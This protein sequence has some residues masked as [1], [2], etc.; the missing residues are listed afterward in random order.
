MK[1]EVLVATMHQKDHSLIEI[2][3]I[4]TDAII[5]NQCDK[6]EYKEFEHNGRI[7]KF[8]SNKER[9]LS[10][11]RNLAIR[12]ATDDICVIADDDIVYENGYES[13]IIKAY[14]EIPEADIIVFDVSKLNSTQSSMLFGEHPFRMRMRKALRVNSIRITFKRQSI[15]NKGI[16][17]N[18]V[19]GAGSIH[20]HGEEN[21]FIKTCIKKGLK[22]F[23]YPY[24]I[25]TITHRESTWFKGYDEKYFYDIGAIYYELFNAFY[26]PFAIRL[27]LRKKG[28]LKGISLPAGINAIIKGKKEYKKRKVQCIK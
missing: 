22:I 4:Q 12:H 16:E 1:V 5:I 2:M 20:N 18:N 3:N 14:E 23:Y 13:E 9:G 19:F 25:A 15:I 24:K 7:I 21:I 10:R 6:E 8:I 11:S 17:F 28:Q 27:L 26:L